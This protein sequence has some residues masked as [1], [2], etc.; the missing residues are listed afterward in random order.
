M[1]L[2]DFLTFKRKMISLLSLGLDVI[3]S[4]CL[5]E[6]PNQTVK[7]CEVTSEYIEDG[8]EFEKRRQSLESRGRIKLRAKRKTQI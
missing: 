4:K 8:N 1:A 5:I 3:T 6:P 2:S 7:Q